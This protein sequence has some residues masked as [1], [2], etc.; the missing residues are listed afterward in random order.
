M[1]SIPIQ[2]PAQFAPG[3]AMSFDTGAGIATAVSDTAPLPV[4]LAAGGGGIRPAPLA[5]VAAASTL[6]GPFA[7]L[8][9]VPIAL[10]LSGTWNGTVRLL[11]SID[12]GTTKLPLTI[13]GSAWAVFSA[14]A[15]EPVWEENEAGA[16]FYLE[17]QLA[18]GT[19]AYRLS[20]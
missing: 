1:P 13:A 5:G 16:A 11:R 17:I 7:P 14:N 18:S 15:C 20:Q 10:A 3:V 19:L 6:V 9:Q 2:Y 4:R 8:A 12:G